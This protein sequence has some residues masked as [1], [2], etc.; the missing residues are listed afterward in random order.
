LTNAEQNKLSYWVTNS[1]L[2]FTLA[3][4]PGSSAKLVTATAAFNKLGMAAEKKTIL[5]RPQDLI[6]VKSEEP[7]ETGNINIERAIVKSNNPFFIRLANEERL[8]EEM[9]MLYMKTGMFLRGAGGYYFEGDLNNAEKQNKWMDLWRQTEFRSIRSYN[10]NDIRKT[11]GRGISGMA[12]GQGELIASPAAIARMASGISNNG[13]LIPNR[14][15]M[16]IS[17]SVLGTKAGIAIAKDS[18]YA[19]LMT[20]YMKAQSESKFAR[21]GIYVA[22]KTGTPERIVKGERINDGWYVFFAPKASGNGHIVVCVRIENCK[23]SSI[24]VRLAGSHIIPALLKRGYIKGFEKKQSQP[25]VIEPPQ[26]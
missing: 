16:R 2:G 3:T 21:L 1:D 8:E 12:W 25:A 18:Q 6:R 19:V 7:D 11:R 23:G 15:V 26:E 22:G 20:R 4:Q 13:T 9:G 24:A 10:P 17:D 14:Y 5:I